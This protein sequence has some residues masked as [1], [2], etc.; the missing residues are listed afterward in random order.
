M[1]APRTGPRIVLHD[2]GL[3]DD[4]NRLSSMGVELVEI[5]VVCTPDNRLVV[6]P[7]AIHMPKS[8]S[9]EIAYTRTADQLGDDRF[10]M[11]EEAIT[12]FGSRGITCVID[13]KVGIGEEERMA[14]VG[15]SLSL[16]NSLVMSNNHLAIRNIEA[17]W[18]VTLGVSVG[19]LPVDPVAMARSARAEWIALP[20][21]FAN[22]GLC[23]TIRRAKMRTMTF[24]SF[25]KA[26]FQKAM[27]SESDAIMIDRNLLY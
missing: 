22:P 8:V 15:S 4:W 27:T 14:Q 7:S 3:S 21:W 10:I 17:V 18:D 1:N 25:T 13:L 12:Y 6:L 16:G 24:T 26:Q 19:G 11:V 9:Y 2:G 5:D 20:S 23:N